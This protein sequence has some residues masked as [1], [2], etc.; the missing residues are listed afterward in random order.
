[1][2]NQGLTIAIRIDGMAETLNAFRAL[3]K[4]A[5]DELREASL[6]LSRKL[7][8]SAKAA[9]IAEGEQAALVARTVKANRDRVPSV[10]AGGSRRVGSRKAPAWRLLFGAEFGS[11]RYRQFPRLHTGRA[12]I[13]FFP[14]IEREAT[15]IAHGWQTAAR[16]I[17]RSFGKA[18]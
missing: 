15:S 9:G 18:V 2:A 4:A 12:G 8:L 14:T 3:P 11:N 5:S 1:M 7:A 16:G 17:V 13:W 6:D 10:T